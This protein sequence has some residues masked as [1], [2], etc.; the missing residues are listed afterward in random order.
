MVTKV[1]DNKKIIKRMK[2]IIELTSNASLEEV[3]TKKNFEKIML[4]HTNDV[5]LSMEQFFALQNFLK[6]VKEEY[7]YVLNYYALS[8]EKSFEVLPDSKVVY[9]VDKNVTYN[10]Y[11]EIFLCELSLIVS[12]N[13]N[14]IIAIEESVEGGVG[15]F[16]ADP[17]L[18]RIFQK[19]IS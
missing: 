7:C 6:E 16:A 2:S 14:W 3:Q 19:Y 17:V 8:D 12:K 18:V 15:I 5:Y 4:L 9:L 10:Q 13:F 1:T 11:T